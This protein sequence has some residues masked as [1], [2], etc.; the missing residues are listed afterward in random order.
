MLDFD[1]SPYGAYIWSAWGVTAVVLIALCV[2]AGLSARYWKS[3]LKKL[4]AQ[5]SAK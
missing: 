3:E 5:R 2:R 4:E 1:M